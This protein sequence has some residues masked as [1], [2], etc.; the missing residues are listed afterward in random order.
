MISHKAPFTMNV[1]LMDLPDRSERRRVILNFH[2][3]YVLKEF[4]RILSIF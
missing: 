2:M 1:N 4:L 3:N